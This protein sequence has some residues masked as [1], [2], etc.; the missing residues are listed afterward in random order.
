MSKCAYCG[1]NDFHTV[2]CDVPSQELQTASERAEITRL[3]A[4]VERLK[5]QINAAEMVVELVNTDIDYAEA[6][7][8]AAKYYTDKYLN[9]TKPFAVESLR[10]QLAVAREASRYALATFRALD[11]YTFEDS[12]HGLLIAEA[13]KKLEALTAIEV[14]L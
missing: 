8:L 12:D 10:E 1:G 3:R 2:F 13:V 9:L 7:S 6:A 4:E 14:K 5:S 11:R